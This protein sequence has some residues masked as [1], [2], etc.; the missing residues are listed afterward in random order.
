MK[1]T[2]Q[3]CNRTF[4]I[5]SD[6]TEWYKRFDIPVP[7]LCP[8]CRSQRRLA[9]R[10]ETSL[11]SDQCDLCKKSIISQYHPESKLTVYCRDC[12]WSDKW[13]PF[14]Y[15]RPFDFTKPF[16]E[17]WG[18]FIRT[19]PHINLLDMNSDNSAYTN[20]VSHNKN[21]Y[22]IFTADY[23]E[24]SLYSNWLQH[25]RD[26]CDDFKLNN[27]ERAYECFF[28]DRLHS[29][30]Y[31]IKCFSAAESLYCYDCR[32]IQNCF[33][34]SNLRNKQYYILNKPYSREEYEKIVAD[35]QLATPAGRDKA[36]AALKQLMEQS[37]HH[38]RNQLGRI[39]AS[40]G[41]YL[42]DVN[43]AWECF[44]VEQADHCRYVRNMIKIKDAMDC[45]YGGVGE[46]GYQ[47]VEP[48]PMPQHSLCTY[49]CYGG[50]DVYYSH[51]VMNSKNVFAS[52]GFKKAEY[53]LFN[54][55][56]TEQNYGELFKK[57]KAQMLQTGEWGQYFPI[58]TSLFGYNETNAQH[59]YPLTQPDVTKHGWPWH[60]PLP[61]QPGQSTV[62]TKCQRPFKYVDQELKFYKE[63]QIPNPT[64]CYSC[65]FERRRQW[66]N[67]QSLW[68]RQCM[69][70]QTDH[71]HNGL[72]TTEFDTTYTPER[73]EIVYC[74]ECYKKEVY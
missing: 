66:H 20:C 12:W 60:E 73:K 58:E 65:R 62:C 16:F 5:H 34:S 54:T 27:G 40:S 35:W 59:W 10:N 74:D 11:Y 28:G 3:A 48:H 49:G 18:E 71:G 13:N 2:C 26:C 64:L 7:E 4:T 44:D 22:L 57:V 41:D 31:L 69:C 39:E 30:Q 24:N 19:L 15:G 8:P 45:E 38:F 37:I 67:P 29:S 53:V 42:R 72:C 17:Q 6:D 14:Q 70:T 56:Y 47:N 63:M 9:H 43:Q 21:S 23:N 32:N 1:K 25:S 50:N 46:N 55:Q 68:H 51:S 33:L 52:C 61:V 36:L